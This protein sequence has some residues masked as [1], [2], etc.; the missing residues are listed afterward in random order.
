MFIQCVSLII[1]IDSIRTTDFI[2]SRMTWAVA[3][4]HF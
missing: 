3:K 4:I 1:K 2:S